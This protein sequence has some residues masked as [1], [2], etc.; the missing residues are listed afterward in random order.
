MRTSRGQTL[1]ELILAVSVL[2]ILAG[3]GFHAFIVADRT[4]ARLSAYQLA[5][6]LEQVQEQAIASG[7]RCWIQLRVPSLDSHDQQNSPATYALRCTAG[8]MAWKPDVRFAAEVR[9][10]PYYYYWFFNGLKSSCTGP[11]RIWIPI[12]GSST[13]SG[14][15]YRQ[16]DF[17]D[18]NKLS[19]QI[20]YEPSGQ[21]TEVPR[22]AHVAFVITDRQQMRQ[23]WVR[24][25]RQ[26]GDVTVGRR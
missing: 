1:L 14:E 5:A 8:Q 12:P 7:E 9:L 11:S 10:E 21:R 20:Q 16:T 19:V 3:A 23:W 25:R 26:T 17:P 24:I 22:P 6:D 13:G 2:L 15:C 18:E 4:A